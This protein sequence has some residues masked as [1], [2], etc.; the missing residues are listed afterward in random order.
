M[1][2]KKCSVTSTE[3][4]RTAFIELCLKET[5]VAETTFAALWRRLGFSM[6]WNKSYTTIGTQARAISQRSFI[7]LF[8]KG[9][10][11]RRNEPALFCTACRT[12][13]AQAELDDIELPCSFNT[14]TFKTEDGKDLSIATTR[15]EL[16]PSCVA[17]FYHP[18]DARY[19]HLAG[20]QAIVPL[21]DYTV[22]LLPDTTVQPD[23]GTGLVMCC[24]FGDKTDILWFKTHNLPY[25]ESIGRNG[26][27]TTAAGFLVGKKVKDAREAVIAKLTER[28]L[29]TTTR[30]ITHSVNIH[31][32]CKKEIEYLA[33][34]Q[35][36]LSLLPYKEEFIRSAATC[37]WFPSFMQSRYINWVDNIGWDWCLSRQRFFGIPFPVWFC[38]SCTATIL[39][40]EATLPV[41]PQESKP[42]ISACQQC[43]SSS[44]IPDTDVMDTW[45]TSSLT[46][47]ICRELFDGD[48]ATFLPMSMRPQAHDIIRTWAFYT[49]VKTWMHDQTHPWNDIVISGHVLTTQGSKISKSESNSPLVPENLLRMYPA[50]VVRH[51]TASAKLGHDVAF[52][53]TQLKLGSRLTVKLWNAFR[54]IKEHTSR[55]TVEPIKDNVA[56]IINQWIMHQATETFTRYQQSLE[57]YEYSHALEIAEKFFWHDFCDNY[58]EL[59]KDQLFN[60]T[61]Y[62]AEEI[63][64]VRA[65]LNYL[66]MCML[67]WFAPFMPYITEQLYRNCYLEIYH[68][69]S[70]HQTKFANVQ[71]QYHYPQIQHTMND[72]LAI[73]N[74]VRKLKSDHQLS[75]KTSFNELIIASQSAGKIDQ[76]KHELTSSETLLKGIT[77]AESIIFKRDEAIT[78]SK[79][80]GGVNDYRAV[81]VV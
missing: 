73:V 29:L 72:L 21:F 62:S 41:D 25:K 20:K 77:R 59:I 75:L 14:I 76:L 49:I 2:K 9:Y 5:K 61:N 33:L 7:D 19:T 74:Q 48:K 11:Y 37:T 70:L 60:P 16:L 68:V 45:N 69:A 32:R 56:G 15:P 47:Y 80:E 4:G 39:P 52:S 53:E 55:Y 34:P 50:D 10:I 1:W 17:L 64:S 13:V 8:K 78:E 65:T 12:S 71:K 67:Q 79:L 18:D 42:P 38:Q 43:G 66:G 40:D 35:W 51:W 63:N 3:L 27:M 57:Q 23:K 36:F 30:P 26:V 54:F 6:D 24:T 28:G 31:E 58:L 81:I 22:P 44:I 46:P